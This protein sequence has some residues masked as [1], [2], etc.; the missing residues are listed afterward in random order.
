M[1]RISNYILS[2]KKKKTF[3]N[4]NQYSWLKVVLSFFVATESFYSVLLFFFFLFFFANLLYIKA[5]E[6]WRQQFLEPQ[7]S[8]ERSLKTLLWSIFFCF[9]WENSG[10]R[11]KKETPSWGSHSNIV[12]RERI[13]FQRTPSPCSANLPYP[14]ELDPNL[15]STTE[16]IRFLLNSK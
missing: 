12:K 7:G 3:K 15:D 10:P 8:E 6:L 16:I 5:G 11:R 2:L 14:V 1:M 13:R 9:K 4:L